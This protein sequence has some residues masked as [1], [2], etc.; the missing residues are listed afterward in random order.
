MKKVL[1]VDD[2]PLNQTLLESY[3][4]QYC[5]QNNE[6]MTVAIANNGI[7]AVLMCEETPYELIFM[8]IIMPSMDGIDATRRISTILPE[9]II[10]IV[11]TED[12]EDN[13]IKALRSGA[14]DYCIKPIQ[15]ELFKR[16]V[17]L[18][19]NMLNTQ[20]GLPSSKQANNLFT[21]D[22]FCFKT[23]YLIE[24]EEDLS[25]LWESLMINLRDSVRTNHLSDLIRFIYQ[26]GLSMLSRHVQPEI[27]I[28]ENEHNFYF[29]VLNV[30]IL[31]AQ[32]IKQ[33]IEGYFSSKEYRIQSNTL[34]FK[35]EKVNSALYPSIQETQIEQSAS[36]TAI[37]AQTEVYEKAAEPL[38][39]FEFMDEEDMVSLE[40]KLNELSTQF[41][42]MGG[43][44]LDHND[45]DQIINAFE[46]ISTILNL[47]TQTQAIGF[48]I[49]DLS[50]LIQNDEADFIEKASQMATLCKSFNSDLILW[51][52]T[53]FFDG[54]PSINYMDASIL[55][56]IQMI[57]SFLE[58]SDEGMDEIEFF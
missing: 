34:S 35:M 54:A 2:Q 56:N 55:S 5:Q 47:Y 11:S 39:K 38:Q 26:M 30:N 51:F 25:Q 3:L 21:N 48:A 28:E 42:W 14:K 12:D 22:I 43:N 19:L 50:M 58:P 7:E 29:S 36:S 4:E 41:M 46:K 40:L 6:T 16:R 13:Q 18:Y 37:P 23:T 31:S 52:K 20:K 8:D 53:I 27:I 33:L 44:E 10:V 49:R 9:S 57:R 32:K 15:P 24:N 17:K 1:I 45:V